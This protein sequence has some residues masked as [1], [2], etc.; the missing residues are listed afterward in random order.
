MRFLIQVVQHA[1][2]KV[3][4]NELDALKVDCSSMQENITEYGYE[5]TI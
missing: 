3:A 5:A 2:I 4:Q 1:R